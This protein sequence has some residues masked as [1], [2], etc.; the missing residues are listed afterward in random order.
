MR[1]SSELKDAILK[2]LLPPNNESVTKVAKE[3]A[4]LTHDLKEEQKA[5][6]KLEK[7]LQRKEKALTETAVELIDEAVNSGVHLSKACDVGVSI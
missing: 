7:E 5:H 3:A 2:R 6:K 1:Y 4:R